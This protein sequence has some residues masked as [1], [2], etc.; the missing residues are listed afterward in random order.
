MEYQKAYRAGNIAVIQARIE[1]KKAARKAAQVPRVRACGECGQSFSYEI[2]RG[3]D[4]RFCSHV[5]RVA[6]RF[7][8]HQ[9][10]ASEAPFCA[11]AGCD[12]RSRVNAKDGL[13][14]ACYTYAWRTG[15]ARDPRRKPYKLTS[16]KRSDGKTYRVLRVPGHPL[17]M[18]HGNVYHHRLVA[19]AARNGVCGPCHWCGKSLTWDAAIVDHLNE[20]GQDNTSSN[21]VL[22]CNGCNRARGSML[23]FFRSLLADRFDELI[24]LMRQQINAD[25]GRTCRAG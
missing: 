9:Q 18:K 14:E 20:N 10:R 23:P 4:R 5:C 2:K 13:C 15:K 3:S 21:L 12:K 16:V 11:T 17:A 6:A 8:R 25:E 1:A 7:K 19:Y 22:S 24:E